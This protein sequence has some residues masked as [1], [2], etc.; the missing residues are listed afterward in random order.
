MNNMIYILVLSFLTN[1]LT[2]ASG[3][4]TSDFSKKVDVF[5]GTAYD[6]NNSKAIQDFFELGLESRGVGDS[7]WY[8]ETQSEFAASCTKAFVEMLFSY[9][10]K[11]QY[12]ITYGTED[13]FMTE[14]LRLKVKVEIEKSKNKSNLSSSLN[15]ILE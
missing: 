8:Y 3:Y 15:W 11:S 4:Q 2:F 6:C 13:L 14:E 10:E 12:L 1:G 5:R 7:E 9:D